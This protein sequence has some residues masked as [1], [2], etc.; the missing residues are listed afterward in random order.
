MTLE[1]W[2]RLVLEAKARWQAGDEYEAVLQ[3]DLIVKRLDDERSRDASDWEREQVIKLKAALLLEQPE[4][5]REA[6][7]AHLELAKAM[8]GQHRS[9]GRAV[10]F[11][12]AQA[13]LCMFKEGREPEAAE[14]GED[15]VALLGLYADDS[16]AFQELVGRMRQFHEERARNAKPFT[17]RRW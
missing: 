16:G 7:N 2:Q 6:G 10:G 9:Y 3:F 4:R 11:A 8:R 15:A 1:E 12:L 13:A 17:S 5:I 14:I